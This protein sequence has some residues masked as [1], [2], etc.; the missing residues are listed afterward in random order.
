[1]NESVAG[2]AFP[3]KHNQEGAEADVH[4]ERASGSPED[5]DVDASAHT[6]VNKYQYAEARDY[7]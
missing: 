6:E 2:T 4:P 3:D 7:T 5:L 1:M